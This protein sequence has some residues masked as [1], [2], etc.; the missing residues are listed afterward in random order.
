MMTH[1]DVQRILDHFGGVGRLISLE[2]YPSYIATKTTQ[3]TF[4]ILDAEPLE[5]VKTEE[6]RRLLLEEVVGP[7]TRLLLPDH[8]GELRDGSAY[9]HYKHMYYSVYRLSE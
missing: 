3:G 4:F 8:T 2:E 9:A 1:D 5:A 6:E 7:V